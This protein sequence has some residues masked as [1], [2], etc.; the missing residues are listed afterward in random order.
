[1]M[2]V[3]AGEPKQGVQY[4]SEVTEDT[5]RALGANGWRVFVLPHDIRD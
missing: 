1:M 4:V 5:S 3:R 2:G